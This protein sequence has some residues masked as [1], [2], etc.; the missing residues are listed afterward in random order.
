MKMLS[1]KGF[2]LL[3]LT[4]V[5]VLAVTLG[6]LLVSIWPGKSPLVTAQGLQV[7]QDLRYA[8]HYAITQETTTR[9]TFNPT[10]MQYALINNNSGAGIILPGK[11][12]NVEQLDTS[13][14]LAISNLP[15]NYVIFDKDG[16]PYSDNAGTV[17]G[18]NATI[19]LTGDSE[20][21][22]VT[23]RANSGSVS[24]PTY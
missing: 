4:I 5:L 21:A 8:R 2:T 9:L 11:S 10:T 19:A 17:L 6:A 16:V 3:E 15:N 1:Y 7:A 12:Q 14:T 24:L 20:T 13:F 23:I 18:T 22:T